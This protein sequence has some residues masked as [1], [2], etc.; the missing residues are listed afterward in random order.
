LAKLVLFVLF[1][2]FPAIGKGIPLMT[3]S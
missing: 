1:L 2:S 3:E